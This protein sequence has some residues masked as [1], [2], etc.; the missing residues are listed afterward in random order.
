M[1]KKRNK[2]T[3]KEHLRDM[4]ILQKASD[5][6]EPYRKGSAYIQFK[7][8]SGEALQG[9]EIEVVQDRQD[10]LFGNLAF[11]LVWGESYQPELFKQRFLEIFNFAIFPFYWSY[12][13]KTPGMTEWR[14][15]LPALE[16]CLANGITPKGH[17]LVWPYDAGVP[18]W[19][20][21]MPEGSVEA[22]IKSR[23]LNTVKGFE[24]YIQAWD[25]TNE[26]VNH[27][28][29]DEAVSQGFRPKYHDTSLWRGI[30]VAGSFKRKIPIKQAAD[31]VEKSFRWAYAAN[32]RA[33]LILND[34][35]QEIELDVRQRFFELVQELQARQVPVSGIGLQVHPVDYWLTPQEIWDTLEMYAPLNVPIHITE[36]HQPAWEHEIEGGWRQGKWNVDVQAEYVEQL[37]RVFYGHPSVVSINYWGLSDRNIWIEGAGLI[38]AEYHP[39]PVF[40]ALKKL[41]KTEW[42]TPAFTTH[43]DAEGKISFRG[44]YGLYDLVV[45]QPG[46][47]YLTYPLHLA[48]HSENTFVFVV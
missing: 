19:L 13:E 3:D 16:W 4:E 42:T 39:K 36:L 31:W 14:R 26:A 12:Y 35:N 8:P 40:K 17:P 32:P 22:L 18:E 15:A 27:I 44:F 24:K 41:I 23:V 37:Y 25:V 6:I 33:T 29:W 30:P 28:S 2:M 5:N 43:T 21:D 9:A 1:S 34:Y 11:D 46:Q 47:K 45:R 48:K 38:D 7:K 10:F 20:Y